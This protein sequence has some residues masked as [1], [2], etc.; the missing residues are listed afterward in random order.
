MENLVLIDGNSILNRAFY[1]TMSSKLM[2]TED[3][4]YTNAV[5]G[6]I[7]IM[8]KILDTEKP[9]YLT[10]AFD[11][12]LFGLWSPAKKNAP[13]ICIEPWYGR[14]DSEEFAGTLED[15]E[16]GQELNVGEAFEVSY[17]IEI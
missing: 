15:R 11:A 3:G 12:P 16:Y 9:E 8:L 2:M 6:F 7:N 4:T 17:E 13:F 10:V 5:Y 14:C 1:G